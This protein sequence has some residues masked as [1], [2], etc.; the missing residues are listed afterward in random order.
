MP[1][2]QE[3][4]FKPALRSAAVS[5]D[6][7]FEIELPPWERLKPE[8]PLQL[9]LHAPDGAVLHRDN[10]IWGQLD[11]FYERDIDPKGSL[12]IEPH[13]DPFKGR[14]VKLTGRVFDEE[15]CH[16]AAGLQVM[17]WARPSGG[18]NAF[19]VIMVA[20]TDSNGYFTGDA[21][22]EKYEDAYGQISQ[23]PDTEVRICLQ[24]GLLPDH[25]ILVVPL[26][27]AEVTTGADGCRCAGSVLDPIDL[28]RSPGA[29]SSDVGGGKCVEFTVPNRTLEE[30]S[31]Y[32]IIRTTEPEIRG[33][34]IS[35]PVF[36]PPALVVKIIDPILKAK[37]IAALLS[38]Q[39]ITFNLPGISEEPRSISLADIA[40][41]LCLLIL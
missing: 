28:V 12:G 13:P 11:Q 17:I 39:P 27:G 8:T 23:A 15:G 35:E 20:C 40:S 3:P 25:V 36:L 5:A 33:L 18:D 31:Y 9:E 16:S 22:R 1:P 26:S 6:G 24:D 30:F 29:Y 7:A 32:K 37:G 21:P 4:Q 2:S 19:N 34:T 10:L 38:R 14:R 41:A